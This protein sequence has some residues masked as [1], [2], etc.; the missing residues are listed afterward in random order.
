FSLVLGGP[1]FQL[2]RKA[3]LAGNHT[4]LLP[5][6]LLT[7]ALG[8]WLPLLLLT[9]GSPAGD[10]ARLSF[11]RDVEV[12][13]RFLIALPVLI[14]AELPV[15]LRI[16]PIVSRFVDW[17]IVLPRDFLQFHRAIQSAVKLRNSIPIE[18]GLW[19]LVYTVGLWLWHNRVAITVSTWYAMPGGRGQLTPA[20]YWYVFISIPVLQFILL[21]WYFRFFIWF[22]FLWQVSRIDLNLIPTH[23]D[24]AAGLA[25]LGKS[26]Y[27]F[28]PILF[29]QGTM[30]AGLVASRVMYRGE[31]LQAFKLQ[32]GGFIAFF[33]VAIL[34]PLVMFTPRLAGVRRKGLAEYG[35][36]AQQYV[37]RFDN[38]WL[39][40]AATPSEELLGAADIQ[41]LADLGNSY[42]LVREMRSI[43][44][45]LE[46][47]SRLAA[48]TAAPFLPL[49]LTVWSPEELIMR[50]VQVVF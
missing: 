48:V 4:E 8:A 49:L 6:R 12:H 5:R 3:H 36:L 1:L 41:S 44:F 42:A 30:L 11:F 19:L 17:R 20:G 14:A 37:E 34:G 22:R 2:L 35:Q 10:S 23:P 18:V 38:R 7:L 45:G 16:R 46:D 33:V 50:I 31:S 39:R 27:A 15:H 32:I 47:I 26:V 25:F 40:G 21:R 24:R 29:A 28:G 43:P 9:L 13:V